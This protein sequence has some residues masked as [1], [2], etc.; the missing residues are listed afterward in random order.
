MKFCRV[1]LFLGLAFQMQS[2]RAE[3]PQPE[4]K[5]GWFSGLTGMFHHSSSAGDKAGA[6]QT[7]NLVLKMELSPMPLKLAENRQFKVEIS[8]FNKSRK[9]VSLEFPTTQRFEIVLRNKAGKQI[10]Q[11]SEDQSF[12]ADQTVVTV[13]P[14]ERIQYEASVATRDL[15]PGAEYVVEGFFP[16]YNDLRIRKTLVPQK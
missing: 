6:V 10:F 3:E 11:W 4:S 1:I 8:L 2:L 12:Q 15:S 9:M 7:R 5:P 14:G 13:N 16:R